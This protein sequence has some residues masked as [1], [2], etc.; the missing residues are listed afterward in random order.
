MSGLQ[1]QCSIWASCMSLEQACLKTF[2]WHT[3]STPWHATP[4][5]TPRW[6]SCVRT[7]GSLFIG[8]CVLIYLQ[9]DTAFNLPLFVPSVS[10]LVCVVTCHSFLF[11]MCTHSFRAWL[12]VRSV[13]P[14]LDT[15]HWKYEDF[16]GRGRRRI[17]GNRRAA[18]K[19]ELGLWAWLVRG[20]ALVVS[21]LCACITVLCLAMPPLQL[22]VLV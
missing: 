9:E 16:S 18:L 14:M 6:P 4:A 22:S 19:L 21:A 17:G 13:L 12:R 3:V 2:S 11:P 20:S 7:R 1:R 10:A 15:G 5:R 8:V